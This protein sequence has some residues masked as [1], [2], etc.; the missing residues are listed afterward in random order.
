MKID[1]MR[2]N[3]RSLFEVESMANMANWKSAICWGE[4]RSNQSGGD[5]MH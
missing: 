1:I 5:K 3:P 4:L 2:E